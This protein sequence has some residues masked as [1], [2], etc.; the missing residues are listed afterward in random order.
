MYIR[1][2]PQIILL[3]IL[4]FISANGKRIIIPDDIEKI[5]DGIEKAEQGDTVFVKKGTYRELIVLKENI[6]LIGENTAET[7]IQGWG[8]G[9]VVMSADNALISN[10]TIENGN[11]GIRCKNAIPIIENVIVR[12][13]KETGIHCIA[14]LPE[15]RN[16]VVY[17]NKWTG[18]F[19]ESARSIKS[20]IQHCVIAE[21]G[22]CGIMLANRSE[23]LIQNNMIYDNKK[24]GIWADE[25]A[26]RSRIVYNNIHGNRLSHNYYAQVDRSNISENP[27][28]PVI[29]GNR[30][31][32]TTP[33]R[34]KGKGKNGT[35]IGF[36]EK[37][38][39]DNS[40][41]GS[42]GYQIPKE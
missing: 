22:Y 23:V 5:Q 34:L 35:T 9:V 33:V 6:S 31:Y 2:I 14:S 38:T 8:Y 40:I 39:L 11:I 10:L 7:V 16:S 15:I 19:L 4:C 3:I 25:Q 42:N 12:S 37:E 29:N 26:R 30:S 13:N 36:L 32:T 28:Y 1:M 17:R 21:N 27:D 41:N 18:I 24:Y 20:S